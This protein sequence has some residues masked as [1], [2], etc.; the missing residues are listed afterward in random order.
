MGDFH[1]FIRN[2]SLNPKI[3]RT[4][5]QIF[6]YSAHKFWTSPY[7]YNEMKNRAKDLYVELSK[8]NMIFFKGDLN[9][10]KLVGDLDWDHCTPFKKALR[11]FYP[12][13][14][15]SLRALK[16]DTVAGLASGK[17]EY[18]KAQ[19]EKWMT[20]GRWATISFCQD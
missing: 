5:F 8:A 12:A 3:C 10:R 9:Y 15:C 7:P 4:I 1:R 14:L 11:G 18:A 19:D 2:S 16:A 17:V 6:Q 13:P 20:S